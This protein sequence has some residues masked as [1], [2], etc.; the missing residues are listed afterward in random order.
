[1]NPEMSPS[2]WI[3][4]IHQPSPNIVRCELTHLERVPIDYALALEQH[5]NY[6]RL[7]ERH[8]A[9]VILLGGNRELPDSVF[10][11]DTAVVLDEIAVIAS[12]GATSRRPE[13]ELIAAELRRHR[14]VT[15]IQL[16]ATLDGG[17]V[18]RVR[19]TLFV[20]L[21]ART[22]QAGAEALR[23]IVKSFG[24]EV[25]TVTVQGCLHLKSACTPLPDDRLLLN[26]AWL[27][28]SNLAGFDYV[29]IAP[30]EPHAADVLSIDHTAVV[31]AGCPRTTKLLKRSGYEIEEVD[32]SEFAKAEGAV[33]CLSLLF[34]SFA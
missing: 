8:G 27:D 2:R 25:R 31:A 1:M 3:A 30:E 13:P 33:T 32:L 15:A 11:E 12:M 16:P 29:T 24:Y 23:E 28:P 34:R 9:K 18:F 6:R 26:P 17:D 22:N 14:E 10:V 19:R 7:L 4:I 5:A 21:S 20:G